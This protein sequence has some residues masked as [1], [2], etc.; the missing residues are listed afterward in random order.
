MCQQSINRECQ[1]RIKVIWPSS[2]IYG[3][4]RRNI[5]GRINRVKPTADTKT[6]RDA[7]EES[8]RATIEGCSLILYSPRVPRTAARALSF[9]K[10]IKLGIEDRFITGYLFISVQGCDII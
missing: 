1:G 8:L 5:N 4:E 2:Q 7:S 6:L 10:C 9:D 3:R